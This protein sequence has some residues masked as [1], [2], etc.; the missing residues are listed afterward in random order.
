M[1]RPAVLPQRGALG[2]LVHGLVRRS[3][4]LARE[5]GK[6]GAVGAACYLVDLTIFNVLR[7]VLGEPIAPKIISTVIA[8]SLAFVGN[9]FWTWRD[10][11]RSGLAR[12]YPLFF[13]VN[14]VGLGIGVACLWVSHNWL[15]SYWSALTTGLADNISG[16]V[17]GVGLA[18]L[19]RFWAYRRFVFRPAPVLEP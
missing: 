2:T 19:F 5:V 18:S 1:S 17:V 8:A 11:T 3:E 6:F 7:Y 9:R 10:R 15:G 4:G 13:L 14:L 16:N 12:E